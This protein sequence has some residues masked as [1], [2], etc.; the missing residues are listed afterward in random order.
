MIASVARDFPQLT[1]IAAHL[2]GLNMWNDVLNN[3][4]GLPNIFMESSLSYQYIQ[5]GLAKKIIRLHG[6]KKIFFGSDYPFGDIAQSLKAA[7]NVDFLSIDERKDILGRNAELFFT[8][9]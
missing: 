6:H 2:G 7:Q 1:I 8:G 5:P 9:P 4:V 3:L